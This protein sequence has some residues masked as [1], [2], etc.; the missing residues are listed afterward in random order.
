[1]T[2]VRE[3]QPDLRSQ[4]LVDDEELADRR[5]AD[6]AR[7]AALAEERRRLADVRDRAADERDRL[8]DQ[9]EID[10]QLRRWEE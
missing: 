8:A 10:A 2:D 4:R 6:V 9:R 5:D 1:M 3:C 7:R